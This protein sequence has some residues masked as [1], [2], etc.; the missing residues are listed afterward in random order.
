[1][2]D[3]ILNSTFA[4]K[5]IE[6]E[7]GVIVE[8]IN[9][10]HD[11]PLMHIESLLEQTIYQGNPLAWDVSGPSK[12]IKKIS[13]DELLRFKKSFYLPENLVI[14]VAGRVNGKI[15]KLI[16]TKFI[17]RFEKRKS[18][19]VRSFPTFKT[20]QDAPR[21]CLQ[22][23]KTKQVQLAI[24]FPA[25]GYDHP[26]AYALHLLSIILGGNMSSRLFTAIRE[27]RGLCYF[28]RCFPNFYHDTGDLIIQS[29]LDVKR[30]EEALSVIQ[31]ELKMIKKDGVSL[32]ELRD[33]K[34]FLRGKITLNLED[35]SNLAEYYA[36]QE[37][38]QNKML[39]PEEKMKKYETVTRRQI[40]KVANE[41]L[42]Q[43]RLNLAAIGPF[44]SK[45]FF[46]QKICL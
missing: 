45:K 16:E 28:I 44:K 37:L 8:E 15:K 31:Q 26:S 21:V 29:G 19:E 17:H 4:A 41:I 33:A 5:E 18:A 42:I 32:K 6:R 13:R 30:I 20:K 46:Y 10:Y 40:E 24:G 25:V 9:M 1:L 14:A 27:K 36:K 3:I 34:E 2:S 39:T 23:R 22:F 38:L 11:N 43:T 35:S 12:V 7:R